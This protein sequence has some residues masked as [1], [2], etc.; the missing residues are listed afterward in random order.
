MKNGHSQS[1]GGLDRAH[2]NPNQKRLSVHQ[3]IQRIDEHSDGHFR[4][5]HS[6]HRF[7]IR[8]QH[9]ERI[10]SSKNFIKP[11]GATNLNKAE[12]RRPPLTRTEVVTRS[13]LNAIFV[14]SQNL[15]GIIKPVRSDTIV[16]YSIGLIRR[17]KTKFRSR[18]RRELEIIFARNPPPR[19]VRR[20]ES[21]TKSSEACLRSHLHLLKARE[22]PCQHNT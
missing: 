2:M 14:L 11:T 18:C 21:D 15:R 12:R 1:V 16:L 6:G 13:Y 22:V 10:Q 17:A 8:K 19:H 5:P 20:W 4:A 3:E 7:S 9:R